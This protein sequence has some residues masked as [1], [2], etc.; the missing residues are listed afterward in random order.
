[1]PLDTLD[2]L[3]DT[4]QRD[5]S[6]FLA[7]TRRQAPLHWID[8]I[9]AWYAVSYELVRE[10]FTHPA[11][12]NDIRAWEGYQ[13]PAPGSVQEWSSRTNLFA[14]EAADHARARRLGSHAFTPASVRL[15]DQRMDEVCAEFAELVD[16]GPGTVVDLAR[17]YTRPIPN[18]VISRILGI[19]PKGD[20]DL[21]FRELA[22]APLRLAN[23]LVSAEEK[24]AAE[25]AAT[26]LIA[27]VS[28][29]V[30]QR[31]EQPAE[32]LV[33]DLVA[34]YDAD[35]RLSDDDVVNLVFALLSAGTDTTTFASTY[36]LRNLV[37]HPDQLALLCDRP[38][39][40]GNAVLELLRFELG[41]GAC[42]RALFARAPRLP[43][44]CC[45]PDRSFSLDARRPP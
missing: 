35:D 12:T 19:P 33:T 38:E 1:M 16:A 15:M 4:F 5:P 37:R 7:N 20:D 32:D 2:P 28:E 6:P 24:A 23:P 44:G 26:E 41:G 45:E 13:P 42:C 43:G 40:L 30:A 14:L 9:G 34:A 29:L 8:S 10:L 31:R 36:G 25:A 27:Y 39:L 17:C 3:T 22:A 21:R 18:A 11:L